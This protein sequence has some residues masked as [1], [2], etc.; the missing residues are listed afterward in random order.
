MKTPMHNLSKPIPKQKGAV[1]ILFIMALPFLLGMMALALDTGNLFIVKTEL[2][3]SVDACA[4]SAGAELD[5]TSAQ[6]NRAQ[7]AGRLAGVAHNVNMQK[8]AV[9]IPND[10]AIMFAQNLD[11]AAGSYI[12]ASAGSALSNA[13]A[14]TYKFVRCRATSSINKLVNV[15]GLPNNDTIT[16]QAIA[17]R[18]PMQTP[19]VLPI[20]VCSN[21]DA[22]T[23]NT[24][25]AWISGEVGKNDP[26]VGNTN[27]YKWVVYNGA[28]P[29]A[30]NLA[31][32]LT[33]NNTCGINLAGQSV[34]EF[35]G[36]AASPYDE[37]N[38]RFGVQKGTN[39]VNPDFTGYG[40]TPAT[41][42]AANSAYNDY[43]SRRTNLTKYQ[44]SL[45]GYTVVQP[46]VS[47]ATARRIGI[48][49]VI[50]CTGG[51]STI[52]N[53]VCVMMLNPIASGGGNKTLYLEF[54]GSSNAG[55][56]IQIGYAG[57]G[58]AGPTVS[59][60]VQ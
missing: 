41:F 39:P 9:A 49:P 18:L 45:P 50:P 51:T 1:I 30:F 47:N 23:N 38:T 25:G 27:C 46:T 34:T 36:A 3:N 13:N 21:A 20:G 37:Y 32:L 12:A 5:G 57:G 29:N 8:V 42:P 56:C 24:V 40:Y 60:L 52:S 54:L 14:A 15:P 59:A 10:S 28:T 44:G 17:S 33:G 26:C 16:A 48:V 7:G 11:D 22:V 2:Q 19:C 58:G 53:Y 31:S 55:S 4:L 43:V 35:S 6:F